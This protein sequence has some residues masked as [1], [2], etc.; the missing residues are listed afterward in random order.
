MDGLIVEVVL[1]V[2]PTSPEN[3]RQY[4]LVDQPDNIRKL[5]EKKARYVFVS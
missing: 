5:V 2:A 1:E 3:D 4:V